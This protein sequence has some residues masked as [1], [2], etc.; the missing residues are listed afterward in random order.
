MKIEYEYDIMDAHSLK[1]K[2]KVDDTYLIIKDFATGE[3][4]ILGWDLTKGGKKGLPEPEEIFLQKVS[5]AID[6]DEEERGVAEK[7]KEWIA[8][9]A[10]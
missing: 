5:D 4:R 3:V 6:K 7:T 2:Y 8:K 1:K 10:T 9:Y